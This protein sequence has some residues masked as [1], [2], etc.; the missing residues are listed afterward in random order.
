MKSQQKVCMFDQN[1]NEDQASKEK[2]ETRVEITVTF[3]G[4]K[5]GGKEI[6]IIFR[7]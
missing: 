2:R 3:Q 6:D 1:V 7:F 4:R 5:K